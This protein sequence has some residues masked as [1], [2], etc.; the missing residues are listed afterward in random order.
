MKDIRKFIKYYYDSSNDIYNYLFE[1]DD[2][3]SEKEK[4]EKKKDPEEE[5]KVDPEVERRIKEKI[6]E[7]YNESKKFFDGLGI[8]IARGGGFV[9]L[10]NEIQIDEYIKSFTDEIEVLESLQKKDMDP[11]FDIKPLAKYNKI[12]DLKGSSSLKKRKPDSE[13]PDMTSDKRRR[14]LNLKPL[15]METPKSED[16]KDEDFI[17]KEKFDN[18]ISYPSG[19]TIHINPDTDVAVS[20]LYYDVRYDETNFLKHIKINENTFRF[21]EDLKLEKFVFKVGYYNPIKKSGHVYSVYVDFEYKTYIPID[22]LD[23]ERTPETLN[24]L[25]FFFGS[26]GL[27]LRPIGLKY[28]LQETEKK[29]F[30]LCQ[31]WTSFFCFYLYYYGIRKVVEMYKEFTKI[32][33]NFYKVILL[34][35]AYNNISTLRSGRF[36]FN[37]LSKKKV[38]SLKKS[39][40][41]KKV[42]SLKKSNS[43][44]KVKSLKKSNSKKKV[45]SLKKS[46]SKKKVKSLKKSDSKKKVKSLKKSNSKKK[47][48]SLK[49]SNSKKKVKSLKKSNSKKKVKSLKKSNSKKKV[50]SLKKSNSKKKVKSLKKSDSKK[51]VK[52]LKKSDSKKKVKSLKKSNSKKK[53]KSLKKVILKV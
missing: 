8:R 3:E 53:V 51:K 9:T 39:N 45:K 43:K 16:K 7:D 31:L 4:Q 12:F 33:K 30:G 6:I 44:K 15:W 36:Y 49:K 21:I 1:K 11:L 2:P 46:D 34:T 18:Q 37:K 38:K 48:K 23:I 19:L 35:W 17:P 40:S 50:K 13:S 32:D 41:E 29:G 20:N 14:K 27:R 10:L 5:K 42:K 22:T 52:S 25:D 26:K 24:F 47:V 28:Y